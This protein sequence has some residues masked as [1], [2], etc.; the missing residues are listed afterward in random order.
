[1]TGTIFDIKEMAVH[2]GPGLRT[3]VFF[4]GCPLRCIWCHNPEGLSSQPQLMYKEACCRHCG[5]C[6]TA[7]T[8]PECVPFGRCIQVCPENC[9]E[10]TGMTVTAEDLTGRLL[11][12]AQIMGDDFGG[13]TFSG[14][15]PLLQSAFLLEVADKLQGQHLCIE[16]SGYAD[17][18]TFCRVLE[19][20]QFVLF[21]VKLADDEQHRRFTGVSNERI[22]R[23]LQILRQSGIPCRIRTPLI[24]SIT[25][26]AENLSAIDRLLQGMDH[27]K[28]A[29]NP[30]AGAKYKMLDME[31]PYDSYKELV[32]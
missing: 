30:F 8:H 26:T 10:I 22:L 12:T 17:E 2:D 14:G 5:K 28:L 25:D 6:A 24:P 19:R 11:D 1:M 9:L 16:T 13:I 20:M 23:N 27:E 29:Y 21:D 3:T 4:K 32:L 15:E 18:D 31:Y 7:C